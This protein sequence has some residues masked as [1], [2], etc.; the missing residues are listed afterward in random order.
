MVRCPH[1]KGT[2]WRN[3]VIEPRNSNFKLTAIVCDSC[4]APAGFL[5]FFNIG[6]MLMAI[7]KT[8]GIS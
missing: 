6:N 4:D 3:E 2:K 7:N 8:L 1:C 5:D